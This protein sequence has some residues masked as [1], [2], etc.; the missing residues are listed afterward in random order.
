MTRQATLELIFSTTV[1][2]AVRRVHHSEFDVSGSSLLVTGLLNNQDPDWASAVTITLDGTS[3]SYFY[4]STKDG[5]I[6]SGAGV[7]HRDDLEV[8]Q[9]TL[10]IDIQANTG[11]YVRFF[12]YHK[13]TPTKV[14]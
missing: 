12:C 11:F 6:T 9:H 5:T 7:F 14:F 8:G 4:A 1:S 2:G 3:S 13:P 10:R